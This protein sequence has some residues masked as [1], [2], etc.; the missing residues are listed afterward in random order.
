M[1]DRQTCIDCGKVSPETETNYTL[2]SAQFGWRLSRRRMANGDFVVEWRC[3][4]C[5]RKRKAL[6]DEPGSGSLPRAPSD[7]AV[8]ARPSAAHPVGKPSGP[9]TQRSSRPPARPSSAPPGS[10]GSRSRRT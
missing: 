9:G 4:D 5:W 8:P 1:R 3:P 7:R 2:I 10:G 6:A